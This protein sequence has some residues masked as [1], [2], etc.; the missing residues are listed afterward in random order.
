MDYQE[1]T[2]HRKEDAEIHTCMPAESI[3]DSLITNLLSVLRIL[4][5]IFSHAHAKG[6]QSRNDFKFGI[7][8]GRFLSDGVAIKAVKGL[9]YQLRF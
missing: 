6:V 7:F 1:D 2:L 8:I 5:E 9:N 4:T 3:F